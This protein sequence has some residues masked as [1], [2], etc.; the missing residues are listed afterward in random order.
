MA[1]H[2]SKPNLDNR[3]IT[4]KNEVL[5]EILNDDSPIP[6]DD[7]AND[8]VD[9]AEE[10]VDEDVEEEPVEE[11]VEEDTPEPI[12]YEKRYKDSSREALTLHFKNK[13]MTEKIEEA[14][15]IPD[16]TEAELREYAF[17]NRGDWDLLDDFSKSLLKEAY[18]N[19]KK[20]SLIEE[21]TTADKEATAWDKK[22]T[23]FV[24]SP[25]T[26]KD[27]PDAGD[28]EV[29]FKKYCMKDTRR[30]M[31]LEDLHASFLFNRDSK[32]DIRPIPKK[33]PMLLQGSGGGKPSKPK[34]P[35]ADTAKATRLRSGKEYRRKIKEGAFDL[36]LLDGE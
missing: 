25:E 16:P 7:P 28:Y 19:S 22:I 34:K 5:E 23:E 20:L 1:K 10:P 13:Q 27:F 15:N 21:A 14:A 17:K 29:E 33:K 32:A 8:P 26:V 11:P 30:G 12:D 4:N 35:T 9:D 18:M 3:K 36:D 2:E 24:N 31:D 6:D